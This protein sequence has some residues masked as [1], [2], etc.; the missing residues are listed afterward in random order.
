MEQKK[1]TF[2]LEDHIKKGNSTMKKA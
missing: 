1:N 2:I